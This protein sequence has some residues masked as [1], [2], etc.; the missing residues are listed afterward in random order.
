MRTDVSAEG[1]TLT[2]EMREAVYREIVRLS[3][4]LIRSVNEI[5][6]HLMAGTGASSGAA[7]KKCEVSVQFDDGQTIVGTDTESDLRQSVSV[8]FMDVLC[9]SIRLCDD[10]HGS[11][12]LRPAH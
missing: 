4:A 10:E 1:F 11:S 9:R 6:V 5:S 8:A 2:D 12:H 3:Q 7:D